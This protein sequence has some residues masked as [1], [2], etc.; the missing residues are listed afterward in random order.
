MMEIVAYR[1]NKIETSKLRT[2]EIFMSKF[3]RLVHDK[4]Y[5]DMYCTSQSSLQMVLHT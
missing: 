4:S 2:W 5:C 3:L 1:L